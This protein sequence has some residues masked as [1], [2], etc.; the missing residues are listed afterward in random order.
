MVLSAFAF[1]FVFEAPTPFRSS[2]AFDDRLLTI[3]HDYKEGGGNETRNVRKVG[4]CR[5]EGSCC[6]TYEDCFGG[7]RRYVS[8][9]PIWQGTGSHALAS[10]L[11]VSFS[12][13]GGSVN[14]E[15]SENNSR[16]RKCALDLIEFSVKR[17]KR[18]LAVVRAAKTRSLF[19]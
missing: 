13:R 17:D 14:G 10:C 4:S 16:R 12:R 7:T 6:A 18:K 9:F 1:A 8:L 11:R 15:L 3:D 19:P 2:S 5:R